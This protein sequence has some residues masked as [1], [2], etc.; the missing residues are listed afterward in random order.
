M[1]IIFKFR[2]WKS[3]NGSLPFFVENYFKKVS[4]KWAVLRI[5]PKKRR[6]NRVIENKTGARIII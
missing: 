6:H 4:G 1:G 5:H 2:M 3:Q